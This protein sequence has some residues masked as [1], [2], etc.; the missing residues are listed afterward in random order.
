MTHFARLLGLCALLS[1]GCGP[2]LKVN[3]RPGAELP[4]QAAAVYPVAF[5]WDEPA[6]R[7]FELS[8]AMVLRVMATDRY[9][10]F[11]PGEFKL[12]R[13]SAANPF[14]GSDIAL[15]LADRGFS[16]MQAV[17]FRPW[18]EKRAQSAIKQ[19]YGPDGK[20][21]GTQRVEEVT[22]LA[23][24]EVF[25]SASRE[26]IADASVTVEADPFAEHDP[27]DP[28]PDLTAAILKLLEKTLSSLK[29]RAP[30]QPLE[31][32]AGF[33]Y[34]WNP[35]A[36]FSFAME[37][38]PP[39]SETLRALDVL[40]QDVAIEARLRFFYPDADLKTLAA[41]KRQPAGLLVT[42]VGEAAAQAG[43]TAGDLITEVHGEPALPQTL[44]RALRLAH[45]GQAIAV[46]V[47]RTSGFSDLSLPVQ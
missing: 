6:F 20:P 46:K 32:A 40:E 21:K 37:G 39:F 12:V 27:A 38:R 14:V 7:S 43:L 31:R 16:A 26:I 30:G 18:V 23:H 34:L 4:V 19:L 33:E 17:V 11:G 13:E 1:S 42:K 44:Q 35:K 3:V 24:L 36:S 29:N 28:Q 22:Y 5:R 15:G 2:S 45:P 10:V 9:A 8:Q 47:R 25:H 41:F